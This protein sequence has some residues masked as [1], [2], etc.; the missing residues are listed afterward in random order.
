M[1][2]KKYIVTVDI[3]G[4]KTNIGYFY[5]GKL[6][7]IKKYPTDKFGPNNIRMITD[8]LVNSKIHILAI[9]LSLTGLIDKKGLWSQLIKK[10]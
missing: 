7:K 5:N 9:C 10:L 2:L 4:T 1:R 3:G 8:I 6:E